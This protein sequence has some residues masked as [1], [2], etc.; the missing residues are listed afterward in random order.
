MNVAALKSRF[1]LKVRN[2][3]LYFS[4]LLIA[5][6]FVAGTT[7]A[8]TISASGA[9]QFCNGGSVTLS[10]TG[11]SGTPGYK[12]LKDGSFIGGA[13][14]STYTATQTGSYTVVLKDG[15]VSDTLDPVTVNA[16]NK[17]DVH[18]NGTGATIIN[19]EPYFKVCSAVAQEFTFTNA[20]TTTAANTNYIIRWGDGS[21]DYVS[22]TFNAPIKHLFPI[23]VRKMTYI[24]YAG[25]CVDSVSYTVF[26][27]NIPAGGLVG[28]G[29][30]TICA[31]NEQRFVIA[32]TENN[33]PGTMYIMY[34]NDGSK[35]DTFYHPAPDTVT[36]IFSKSSCGTSSSNGTQTFP[37]SFGAFLTILNPCGTAGGSILP[38]YVSDKPKAQMTIT[39][40][41]TACINQTLTI[42]NSTP[43]TNNVEN[44]TC[45][46]IKF[47]WRVRSLT[48]GGAWVLSSGS[49]GNDFGSGNPGVWTTGTKTL[50]I[51]FTVAGTYAVKLVMINNTL[52]GADSTEKLI[53]VNPTPTAN[54]T[55]NVTSGCA[56]LTVNAQGTTNALTC[57]TGR[58]SWSVAYTATT[59]CLPDTASYAFINGTDAS[60]VNPQ[61]EFRTPGIY[62]LRLQVFAPKNACSSTVKEVTI[63]VKGKPVI[64]I[65]APDEI[66][67]GTKIR[68]SATVSCYTT[69][70]TYS[71]A[72]DGAAPATFTGLVPD[73]ILHAAPGTYNIRLQATN[74][75]GTNEAVRPVT[76]KP[77]PDVT[78]PTSIIVCSG[79]KINALSFAGTLNGT[80]FT[81]TNDQPSIGLATSG[82]NSIPTFT[83][84]NTGTTTV[85][86]TIRVTPSL[87]GCTGAS[88]LFTITVKPLPVSPVVNN[89]IT[90]CLN[91]SASA[92]TATA[93]PGHTLVWYT[94]A[95]GGTP[96]ATAPVPVTTTPGV[97]TYYV[98]QV[99]ETSTCESPRSS[100]TVTVQPR[101]E[102]TNIQYSVCSGQS[103]NISPAGAPNGT[104][105]SW[106][107]PV[108]SNG[109]TGGVAAANQT[110]VNGTLVNTTSTIQTATYTVTPSSGICNGTSFQV[111]VEVKPVPVITNKNLSICSGEIFEVAPQNG[112]GSDIV[113]S[114]VTYTWLAPVS[115]PEGAITGGAAQSTPVSTIRQLLM[116]TT[117]QTATLTYKVIP[118]VANACAGDTFTIIVTVKP[119]AVIPEQTINVC[120]RSSFTLQ[121]ANNPPTVTVPDGTLYTW[122]EPV[123]TPAGS[124]TG[125]SAMLSP[126][127]SLQ[128]TLTNTTTST[129]VVTYTITPVSGD[130]TGEPFTVRVYVNP[131]PG[132]TDQLAEICSHDIFSVI[133]LNTPVNTRYTWGTPVS[134]PSGAITGGAAE[135]I[136]QLA[137]SQHLINT[138]NET[139]TVTYTVTPTTGT[140]SNN[141]FQVQVKVFPKPA[142]KDTLIAVCTG[143]T[144]QYQPIHVPAYSVVPAGTKMI[145]NTPVVSP[146]GAVTGFT[147]PAEAQSNFVQTLI[148]QTT[149]P[150]TVTYTVTPYS[151]AEGNC[152]GESFKVTIVVQP[153]AKAILNYASDKGCAPFV[154][155]DAVLK[156]ESPV[157][158][159]NQFKWFVNGQF[160]SDASAFPGYTIQQPND[161]VL[162]QLVA[163]NAYGCKNDTV[164]QWYHSYPLPDISFQLATD[165]ICG[166][167]TVLITNNSTYH[168]LLH[169]EWN[170]GNGVKSTQFQPGSILFS[171]AASYGDTSYNVQLKIWNECDTVVLTKNIYVKSAPKASFRPTRTDACSPVRVV[172]TNT[173]AGLN[174]TYRWD[175]GDGSPVVT[176]TSKDTIGHTYSTGSVTIYNVR[177]IASNHCGSDT[178]VIPLTI[179]PNQI[180]LSYIV[181][182]NNTKGCAPYTVKF[183]SNSTGSNSYKWDFG[184]GEILYTTKGQD[185][186]FHTYDNIGAFSVYVFSSNGC[187][188]T[189]A[190]VTNIET[191]GKPTA[192]F[193]ANKYSACVGDSIRFTNQSQNATSFRWDFGNGVRNTTTNPVYNYPGGGSF[194]ATLVAYKTYGAGV[195]CSDSVKRNVIVKDTTPVNFKI[196]PETGYCIPMK[197]VFTHELSTAASTEWSFGDGKSAT[198]DVAEHEYTSNGNYNAKVVVRAQ[199]GCIYTGERLIRIAGPEGT[200]N[201]QKGYQCI[202]SAIRFEATTYNTDSIQWQFGNGVE[203]VTNSNVL[204]YTYPSPGI[205]VPKAWLKTK[206]GCRVPVPVSDT[207]KVDRVAAGF[208]YVVEENCGYT[209]VRFTDTSRS[210]FGAVTARWSFGDGGTATGAQ[211]VRRYTASANYRIQLVVTGVSGCT[212]TISLLL[213]VTV[214]TKPVAAIASEPTTCTNANTVFTANILSRDNVGLIKWQLSNGAVSADAIFNYKFSTTGT[215]TITLVAGT[216]RGCYDT[217]SKTITV[218]GSPVINTTND[219]TI[220]KGKSITLT[221]NGAASYTWYP[222]EGL[223]CVTCANTTAAP[224]STTQYVVKGTSANGC[225][226]V[227]TVKI[228]V[229]QPFKITVSK[230]D[231]ICIGKNL[232]LSANGA[233]SYQWSPAIGLNNSTSANPVASPSVSTTYKVVGFDNVSCFTD[234]AYIR[235]G[236]GQYPVVKLGP[237]QT[238]ATGTEFQLKASVTNGPIKTW[239]WTPATDLSCGTCPDP[240]ATVKNDISYKVVAVTNYGCAGSDT[241]QIKA[242]CSNAQVFVPSGFTPDGDGNN[243]IMMVRAK[244]VKTI[245]V[246]RI[247]NRWGEMVF[248]RYNFQPNDA[249]AG[250]DGTVRGAMSASGVFVYTLE[251][252]CENGTSYTYKGNITLIR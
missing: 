136:P 66:C 77:I 199:G 15:A 202:Q 116:N 79:E 96:S 85:T 18:L 2:S 231:S 220:C 164:S 212:D 167:A 126:V 78:A 161:S 54:F 63:E 232:Q 17:P 229:A 135:T 174:T 83:A 31:G 103:F 122:G 120:S 89:A 106:S 235:V 143:A 177:L 91:E 14:Q 3:L 171:S 246:F 110:S 238:L 209:D 37:N 187:S 190:F 137:V 236:V 210:Y 40:T 109:I 42:T 6:C 140:C 180:K 44:G 39:P 157:T 56:P 197:V 141:T 57:G 192:A 81:W 46:P 217:V 183:V 163:V 151:G 45:T 93:L 26:V 170:F 172:F 32:G 156:N 181:D 28:V 152:I 134:T 132:I 242:F 144:I 223:N 30:S 248:E 194:T 206:A 191:F 41:D 67:F 233:S 113:P 145:W 12:W 33:P 50:G 219:A 22:N 7:S 27:G 131:Q 75:C 176:T 184:D 240:V 47:I 155:N 185:T 146:A 224:L 251:A 65:T 87:N 36:H 1:Q 99:N 159:S 124:V 55:T 149:A 165:T 186:V 173:S 119:K 5:F 29:G 94:S 169:Y 252:V 216:E 51:R 69:G 71:W 104:I 150:A 84:I 125:A 193:V 182:G 147:A 86:A 25:A 38:I 74:E 123:V 9:L 208:R 4:I 97:T 58:F 88:K 142:I 203:M 207:I 112:N 129:A 189:T 82:S 49:L 138:S 247:F 148:N 234:T 102:L 34:Y 76:V 70:A 205:Y 8:Q 204:Y 35:R 200:V 48:P 16:F 215:Q 153:N 178:S 59:G 239:N 175:F 201:I 243:D 139:A 95:T 73:S 24:V 154:L 72:F 52:C 10:V 245:K 108:I 90:Y 241:I 21:A 128:Q 188:D 221:A 225:V 19:G 168:N 114:S 179:R 222:S 60:S 158:A 211:Q 198:G 100:I 53:C 43:L 227:D 107:A 111:I 244:G 117:N 249:A 98:S 118:A 105:Y 218:L 237:D 250:W 196:N 115:S 160:V 101:I 195:T 133:P 13:T 92:L 130:C 64:R 214:K 228:T 121:P 62:K 68:P 23:G 61:I 162:I 80:T 226:G 20:S 166:P 213:P 230:S 127:A 11:A